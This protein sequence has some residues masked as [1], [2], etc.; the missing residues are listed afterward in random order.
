MRHDQ[1]TSAPTPNYS[2][3]SRNNDTV[4]SISMS[5]KN[6]SQRL[7]PCWVPFLSFLFIFSLSFPI[8]TLCI[9]QALGSW[10]TSPS[11]KTQTPRERIKNP[12]PSIPSSIAKILCRG[13][14]R[15]YVFQLCL[16]HVFYF[17]ICCV[18][19]ALCS[20]KRSLTRCWVAIHLRT[21]RLRQPVSLEERDFEVK[22]STQEVKQCSTRPPKAPTNSLT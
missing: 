15:F 8:I 18:I 2:F 7:P 9:I 12:P 3:I 22:S 10:G 21:Q 5:P 19:W 4:D 11:T 20:W 13:T 6:V 17:C 16:L 14:S 1:N